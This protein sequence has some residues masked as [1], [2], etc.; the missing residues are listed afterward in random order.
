MKQN[1]KMCHRATKNRSEISVS[2]LSVTLKIRK[3]CEY[4]KL[5]S[6]AQG[7]MKILNI[8]KQNIVTYVP[9]MEPYVF[10]A[11]CHIEYC[12]GYL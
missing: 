2:L 10:S 9:L 8:R 5:L 11:C 1:L 7:I 4:K 12:Q 6:E 3:L